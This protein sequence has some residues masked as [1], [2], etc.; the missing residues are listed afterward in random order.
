MAPSVS[1]PL[2][3]VVASAADIQAMM[4]GKGTDTT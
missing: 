4:D 1:V 2:T 3:G